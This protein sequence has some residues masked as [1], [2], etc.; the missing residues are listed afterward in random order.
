MRYFRQN[1]LV[2]DKAVVFNSII[3]NKVDVKNATGNHLPVCIDKPRSNS[4][5]EYMN[6][7]KE[8]LERI[9]IN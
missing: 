3:T 5:A 4:T 6:L 1:E 8:I 2:D 9:W 7:C